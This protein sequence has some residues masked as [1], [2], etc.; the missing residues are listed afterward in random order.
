MDPKSPAVV[1]AL[2]LL[3]GTLL[4]PRMVY[5]PLAAVVALLA[6]A[7]ALRKRPAWFLAAFAMGLCNAIA[8]GFPPADPAAHGFDLG[9][10]VEIAGPAT[11]HPI[12]R[13]DRRLVRMRADRLRQGHRISTLPLELW[14]SLPSDARATLDDGLTLGARVRLRGYLR[15]SPGLANGQAAE[16]PSLW[17]LRLKSERFLTVEAPAA[18]ALARVDRLRRGVE[19]L[20]ASRNADSRS[21]ALVRSLVLADR[22]HL[23]MS[24]Q[25]SLRRSGLVHLLAVSGLHIGLLTLLLLLL[26]TPL[27]FRPRL[28]LVVLGVIV[29]LLLIGPGPSALRASAMGLL[30]ALSLISQRPPQ[31]LNTLACGVAILVLWEP[32]MVVDLGFQLSVAATAGILLLAPEPETRADRATCGGSDSA[33]RGSAIPIPAWLRRPLAVSF[34]AQLATRPSSCR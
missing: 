20:F 14:L 13:Q 27:G 12:V 10:P 11:S 18:W 17:R 33:P 16:R 3:L 4:A 1:P 28:L 22:S 21:L 32:A 9:R 25:Q 2:G 31:A 15:R 19:Q 29:Y 8:Q 23:P 26:G 6:F 30:A 7:L 24:W 5:L 34:A